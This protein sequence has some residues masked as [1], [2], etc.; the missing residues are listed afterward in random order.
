[1]HKDSFKPAHPSSSSRGK[2]GDS[3][4]HHHT[5]RHRNGNSSADSMG[6]PGSKITSTNRFE[7]LDSDVEHEV[8][9]SNTSLASSNSGENFNKSSSSTSAYLST[10][11]SS[12]STSS[13]GS[14]E[15]KLIKDRN[16]RCG[17]GIPRSKGPTKQQ[18][19]DHND[20]G[21]AALKSSSGHSFSGES[22]KE[23]NAVKDLVKADGAQKR[24]M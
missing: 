12:G 22:R 18:T 10:S 9:T 19:G 7:K 1:M 6:K 11:A 2:N 20:E 23:E 13:K 3:G 15:K 24:N 8:S 5:N 21:T 14:G 4:H 17:K 16:G